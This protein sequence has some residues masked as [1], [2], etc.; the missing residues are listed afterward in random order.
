MNPLISV[1]MSTYNREGMIKESVDSILNQTFSDFEFIIIDDNSTDNTFEIIKEYK[2]DRIKLFRNEKN[3]G[4]TFNYHNAQN[5]AKG[6]YIAH[7]DDD[8]IS[9]PLRFEKQFEYMEE[10]PNIALLGSFIETF[11]E[12]VRPSWVFYTDPLKLDF[13]MNF[14]NPLCHSS[15]MYRKSFV[16]DIGINYDISK[17]CAQ[18]Y[19]FYKQIIKCGGKLANLPNILVRYRMHSNRLT[20]IKNTQDIQIQNAENIIKELQSRFLSFEEMNIVKELMYGFP[21]NQYN[22]DSVIEAIEIMENALK[23]TFYEYREAIKD[24]KEDIKNNLFVF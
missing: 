22:K 13:S 1:V 6:K 3:S 11:G 4:C 21:F 5:I 23:S 2:D 14:Y 15:I 17:K 8:D 7:I 20:D 9:L 12:N 18:D 10:Y 19:D 24:V 16:E